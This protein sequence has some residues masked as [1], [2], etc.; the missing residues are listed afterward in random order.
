[1]NHSKFFIKFLPFVSIVVLLGGVYIST[2]LI[3][4]KQD[5][6][7]LAAVSP[8]VNL[9]LKLTKD[10]TTGIITVERAVANDGYTPKPQPPSS[11]S[12]NVDTYDL[13]QIVNGSVVQTTKIVFSEYAHGAPAINQDERVWFAK[14][15]AITALRYTSG[16]QLVLKNSI[17]NTSRSLD[18]TKINTAL[19]SRTSVNRSPQIFNK[20]NQLI[21][22]S[23]IQENDGYLDLLF[24]SSHYTDF[25]QFHTDVDNLA[26]F[27][28]SIDPFSSFSSRVRII[29]LDN[30]IELGC[31]HE[32]RSIPCDYA[33]VL[34]VASQYPYDKI[35]VVENSN[36]YG[37]ISYRGTNV[38][39]TYRDTSGLAG[40]V[41]VHEEGHNIVELEDE[42]SW[43][44]T[45]PNSPQG[46]NCSFS[47]C[48]WQGTPG[49]G[50]FATCSYDNWY[51]PTFNDSLMRTLTPDHGFQFGPVGRDQM[52]A[53]IAWY[54]QTGSCPG[55]KDTQFY[56]DYS[57]SGTPTSWYGG[58]YI[59]NSHQPTSLPIYLDI[60][61]FKNSGQGF[62]EA[63]IELKNNSGIIIGS[64][65]TMELRNV[66][67]NAPGVY[68]AR[69]THRDTASCFDEDSFT[70]SP[71]PSPTRIPTPTRTPTPTPAPLT[72]TISAGAYCNTTTSS[73][74]TNKS[75]LILSTTDN[76]KSW[77]SGIVGTG[78]RAQ[79]ITSRVYQDIYVT[80]QDTE[81]GAFL[82]PFYA[83][84]NIS[85]FVFSKYFIPEKWMAKY[86]RT[87]PQGT[88]TIRYHAP[89]SWCPIPTIDTG[90]TSCT[91]NTQC[92]AVCKYSCDGNGNGV[93]GGECVN[94]L[95]KCTP[96]Q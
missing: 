22:P 96:C 12:V 5:L 95:C 67:I 77:K 75:L 24:I 71:T 89:S 57:S 61:C 49:T 19:L 10:K 15:E 58:D 25:N 9:I 83:S 91:T 1:M 37:G 74:V 93:D 85:Q 66:R 13:Q 36:E 14:P 73:L 40:Q 20:Q 88:Y 21:V 50:C 33:T 86:K 69:C 78:L 11:L 62:T 90:G 59:T 64:S 6:Q 29:K 55:G 70:I 87:L 28:L 32:G 30:T 34:N 68:T 63:K 60:N 76:N 35:V 7:S 2:Q 94:S 44:T 51:R 48:K 81:S 65:N 41:L 17:T 79:V 23:S 42:Y 47:P 56:Y 3:K 18:M 8:Q 46:A 92:D 84:P 53:K 31:H 45:S 72:W 4:Q 52:A 54:T 26:N 38:V 80:L 39:T 82:Q 27:M 16:A 43:G